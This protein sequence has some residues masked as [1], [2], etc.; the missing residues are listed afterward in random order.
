M[1]EWHSN[2]WAHSPKGYKC[3]LIFTWLT[4]RGDQLTETYNWSSI[5]GKLKMKVAQAFLVIPF[6]WPAVADSLQPEVLPSV[7][8]SNKST[9]T[10]VVIGWYLPTTYSSINLSQLTSSSTNFHYLLPKVHYHCWRI[11]QKAYNFTTNTFLSTQ[12][13]SLNAFMISKTRIVA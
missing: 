3:L 5:S 13:S 8:L 11:K 12:P 9:F 1:Q 7:L 6:K 4:E 2:K 10:T